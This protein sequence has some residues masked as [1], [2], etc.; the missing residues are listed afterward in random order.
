MKNLLI[1]ALLFF[2]S[3]VATQTVFAQKF[4]YVDSQYILEKIPEY[5][6]AQTNLDKLSQEW[7][8]EVEKRYKEIENLYS[9]YQ[10]EAVLL[11]ADMKKQREDE[12]I[13]KEQEVQEFQR[14]KFGVEGELFRKREELI[15]PI[16]DKVYEAIK[17]VV[18]EQGYEMIF[19]KA[20]QSNILYGDEKLDK[21]DM[22]LRRMGVK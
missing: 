21:S 19:D 5:Q 13:L 8:A 14:L 16:Q 7:Q 18:K 3:S 15:Q 1:A 10:A 22:V 12:I 2:V 4:A 11:S 9:S 20:N 17:T 6:E